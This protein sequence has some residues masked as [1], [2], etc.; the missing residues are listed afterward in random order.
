MRYEL[1]KAKNGKLIYVMTLKSL[2]VFQK[3]SSEWLG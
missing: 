2:L 3:I 1:E